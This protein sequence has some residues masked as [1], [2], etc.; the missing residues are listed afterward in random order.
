[1]IAL[2]F[3]LALIASPAV[4]SDELTWYVRT[5]SGRDAMLQCHN[6]EMAH[7][8]GPKAQPDGTFL[9]VF[10]CDGAIFADGFESGD[11][12]GWSR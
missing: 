5:S 10:R 6:G 1:M 2:F 8:F 9:Q 11:T 4:A 7:T 12:A 3:V